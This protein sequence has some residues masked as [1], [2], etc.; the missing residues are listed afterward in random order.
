MEL[1]IR[2]MLIAD[3]MWGVCMVIVYM[4]R[5]I[6]YIGGAPYAS[7]AT[8]SNFASDHFNPSATLGVMANAMV[9][10]R[11]YL[12]NQE[13]HSCSREFHGCRPET[14][15]QTLRNPITQ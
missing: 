7:E 3:E 14:N 4:P 15:L 12:S 9:D 8:L 2:G 1:K 11:R 10:D 6:H 5:L 13:T